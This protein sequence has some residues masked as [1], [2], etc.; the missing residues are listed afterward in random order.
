MADKV[1]IAYK[2]RG[3]VRELSKDDLAS[4]DG[5]EL[6]DFDF[7]KTAFRR[8]RFIEVSRE[9]ADILLDNEDIFGKFVEEGA[10]SEV[11]A[12]TTEKVAGDDMSLELK[13]AQ[14][15]TGS[16]NIKSGAKSSSKPS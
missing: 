11:A 3:D 1:K 13:A 8:H 15:G 7:K 6:E 12:K 2:G 14:A 9:A 5:V 16:A 10:E 4:V